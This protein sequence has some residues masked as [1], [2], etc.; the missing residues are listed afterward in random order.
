MSDPIFETTEEVL[1]NIEENLKLLDSL[2]SPPIPNRKINT[3]T[4]TKKKTKTTKIKKNKQNN[5]SFSNKKTK[6]TT[7][8]KKHRPN[9]S[10]SYHKKRNLQ[11]NRINIRSDPDIKKNYYSQKKIQNKT[12]SNDILSS[13]DLL[14]RLNQLRDTLHQNL[15]STVQ[16]WETPSWTP[17][18]KKQKKTKR[19]L[20]NENPISKINNPKK[21]VR[22]KLSFQDPNNKEKKIDF[23]GNSNKKQ[24]GNSSNFLSKFIKKEKDDKS[25]Q[26]IEKEKKKEKKKEKEKEK[27][28]ENKREWEKEQETERENNDQSYSDE[29]LYID[30]KAQL[31]QPKASSL[32]VLPSQIGNR[33]RDKILKYHEDRLDN[34]NDNFDEFDDV[35]EINFI[36]SENNSIKKIQNVKRLA[37]ILEQKIDNTLDNQMKKYS[38]LFGIDLDINTQNDINSDSENENEI[39][40]EIEI[41]I[42]IE[43]ENGNGNRNTGKEKKH[44]RKKKINHNKNVISKK[45]IEKKLD[46][47]REESPIEQNTPKKDEKPKMSVIT[48]DMVQWLPKMFGDMILD[49]KNE[50]WI[51]NESELQKFEKIIKQEEEEEEEGEKKNK[52]KLKINNTKN[53]NSKAKK[54]EKQNENEKDYESN[55][56]IRGNEEDSPKK[57]K[58]I[59]FISNVDQ[60]LSFGVINGMVFNTKDR[61]WEPVDGINVDDDLDW[62]DDLE[63]DEKSEINSNSNTF[64]R[65][66]NTTVNDRYLIKDTFDIKKSW[67]ENFKKSQDVHEKLMN[68]WIANEKIHEKSFQIKQLALVWM[69]RNS[70]KNF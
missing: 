13:K 32:I 33:K 66:K 31:K 37:K 55:E 38:Q 28:I 60:S 8:T 50:E 54:N 59:T 43:K 21:G 30:E 47:F 52:V 15:N 41:E 20:F 18:Q 48:P 17:K 67:F 24:N 6:H 1:K 46:S 22:K 70:K 44:R 3:K 61:R 65:N 36:K 39:E 25:E 69:I 2:E 35:E 12:D 19:E 10:L 64:N 5:L 34:N 57:K 4:N 45:D 29:D 42:E 16:N 14:E 49:E 11:R 53:V 40:N 62:G 58:G 27:E 23:N 51:G 63:N 26:E 68:G 7:Q 9:Q 56:T